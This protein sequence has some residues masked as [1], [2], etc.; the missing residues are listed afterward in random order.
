MKNLFKAIVLVMVAFVC[1]GYKDAPSY[2][3]SYVPVLVGEGDTLWEIAD[4]HYKY[5]RF[6]KIGGMCFEEYLHNVRHDPKN[7]QLTSNGRS[8]Q[9]GDTVMVPVYKV[10]DK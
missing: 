8:L 2:D 9:P 3:V 4:G 7:E 1:W 6:P 10:L 5:N